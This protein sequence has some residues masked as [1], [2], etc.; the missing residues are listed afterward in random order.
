MADNVNHPSHYADH[1]SLECYKVMRLTYGPYHY[2][3]YCLQN[4]FKYMWR[5]KFKNGEEDLAKAE[6]YLNSANEI[7]NRSTENGPLYYD[8]KEHYDEIRTMLEEIRSSTDA[9]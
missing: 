4:A 5:Y 9:D 7:L 2:F 6:W 8:D 1:C 3:Y